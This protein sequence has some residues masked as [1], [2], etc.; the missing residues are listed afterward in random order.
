VNQLRCV[1]TR[2]TARRA[3]KS[4]AVPSVERRNE[5]GARRDA[6]RRAGAFRGAGSSKGARRRRYALRPSPARTAK[7]LRRSR[8]NLIEICSSAAPPGDRLPIL[9]A[10]LTSRYPEERKLALVAFDKVLSTDILR[11]GDLEHFPIIRG[12]IRRQRSS[13]RI[14]SG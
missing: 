9:V 8:F 2:R 11:M 14:L 12:R 10:L 6:T 3:A 1:V 4:D 13:F 7:F 5:A